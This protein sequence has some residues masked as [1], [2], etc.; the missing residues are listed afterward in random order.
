MFQRIP[1]MKLPLNPRSLVAEGVEKCEAACLDDCS[2]S[3]YSYN[4]SGCFIWKG[5]LL[6]LR[7]LGDGDVNGG[8]LHVRVSADSRDAKKRVLALSRKPHVQ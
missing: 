5:D 8:D 1:N 3:A 2:C 6:N 4:G 7:H